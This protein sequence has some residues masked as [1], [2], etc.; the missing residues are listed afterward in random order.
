V[1]A[2]ASAKTL[3]IAFDETGKF[4]KV[5]YGGDLFSKTS[6]AR[7][8]FGA[9][10]AAA[11]SDRLKTYAAGPN[12]M[13][14][15]HGTLKTQSFFASSRQLDL[16]EQ[17]AQAKALEQ[18]RQQ[19][20]IDLAV[21]EAKDSLAEALQSLSSDELTLARLACQDRIANGRASPDLIEGQRFAEVPDQ[22]LLRAL[23]DE[24]ML[25]EKP[26]PLVQASLDVRR[27]NDLGA[28]IQPSQMN[29][30]EIQHPRAS[31]KLVVPVAQTMPR[32]ISEADPIILD[33]KD[34]RIKADKGLEAAERSGVSKTSS[35]GFFKRAAL[36]LGALLGMGGTV[37]LCVLFP[38]FA[39]LVFTGYLLAFAGVG[40]AVTGGPQMN[41][42]AEAQEDSQAPA[43][44]TSMTF[45]PGSAP[46]SEQEEDELL[47]VT[48]ASE[49]LRQSLLE[50]QDKHLNDMLLEGHRLQ[51][52]VQSFV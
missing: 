33:P 51:G 1:N 29:E 37:A 22:D 52:Q 38:P 30:S 35:G 17:F 10:E 9:N 26:E 31:S 27:S 8:L 4:N 41:A 21:H 20:P 6:A 18:I 16:V 7:K 23:N 32:L 34:A 28:L 3:V 11:T 36:V 39:P 50:S 25:R 49:K 46:A 44:V 24:E 19:R 40:V 43:P 42:D 2:M 48:R 15:Y 5:V 14:A 12:A 47:R 45:V 13:V